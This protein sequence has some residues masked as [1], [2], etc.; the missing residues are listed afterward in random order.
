[1]DNLETLLATT[2]DKDCG[3]T[4]GVTVEMFIKPRASKFFG[5]PLYSQDWSGPSIAVSVPHEEFFNS[6]FDLW[7]HRNNIKMDAVDQLG[8]TKYRGP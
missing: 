8:C 1:M 4:S 6:A 5:H 7:I 3:N 2:V